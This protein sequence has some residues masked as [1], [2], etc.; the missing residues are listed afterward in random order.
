[1]HSNQFNNSSEKKKH[2]LKHR[3]LKQAQD[4][5]HNLNSLNIFKN[6]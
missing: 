2:F 5:I 1:M 3:L 4:K 6:D